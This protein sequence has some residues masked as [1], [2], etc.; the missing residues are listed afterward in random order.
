MIYDSLKRPPFSLNDTQV[1]EVRARVAAMSLSERAAQVFILLLLGDEEQYFDLVRDLKPG[2]ITRFFGEDLDWEMTQMQSIFDA[3]P[4]PPFVTADLEGSRQSFAF[5]TQ[6]PNQ[7]ALSAGD[8]VALTRDCAAIMARE[9]QRLGVNW[10]FTPVIDINAAFRSAIVGS[11]SYGSDVERIERHALAHIEGLQANGFAATVKHWPGEGFDDRDQHLVTTENPLTREE[12]DQTFGRLYRSTFDAGVMAVMSAHIAWPNYIRS[13]NPDAGPEEAYRPATISRALTTDL[14]RGELGFNGIVVSDATEMAGL[15]AWV[16][17]AEAPPMVLAAGCDVI[18]FSMDPE[19]DIATV[20]R[21]VETGTLSA[22]RLEEAVVRILALKTKLGLF[23]GRGRP[24]T[25]AALHDHLARPGDQAVADRAIA[26]APTLVKDV[27]GLLPIS[28]ERQR[29]VLVISNDIR[30]PLF[31]APLHFD[32]PEM[33]RHEGFEVEVYDRTKTFE[34]NAFDLV[35][36]LMGDE[37]L[38]TRSHIFIDWRTMMQGLGNSL[39]R[40]WT[41]VPTIMIGFGHPYYLYDAP[42]VPTYIN[43]YSTMP[44]MQQAVVEALLGRQPFRGTSPVDAFCG[45]EIARI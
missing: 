44:E 9:G 32:L 16:S 31:D 24:A 17:R 4:T 35:L 42:R 39:Y 26:N 27:P 2:G 20:I 11:R 28:P 43:A 13:L 12:W 15:G 14:L 33:L 19:R 29:R 41:E 25:G 21:A 3:L 8:D 36:Y 5:G 30:H 45:Q 10:S 18:L 23:E 7:L 1:E 22:Q 38:F 6:V 37:S 40:P 34:P